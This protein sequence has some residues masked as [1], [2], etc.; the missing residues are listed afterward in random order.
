MDDLIW[1]VR[2]SVLWLFKIVAD[3][4]S[5][6]VA[7][8]EPGVI[9]MIRAGNIYGE[10]LGPEVL[11]VLAVILLVPLVMAFLTLILEGS[12]NRWLNIIVGIVFAG[13][14]IFSFADPAMHTGHG[15]L[16]SIA[17]FVAPVLI[18]WYAWKWPKKEG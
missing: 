15:I 3:L 4:A 5:G 7:L 18:V 16:M 11:F 1:K 9:D 12:M 2:I 6:M 8:M 10:V 17:L 14:G 13:L